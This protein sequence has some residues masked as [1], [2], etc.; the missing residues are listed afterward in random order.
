MRPFSLSKR[1]TTIKCLHIFLDIISKDLKRK[2]LFFFCLKTE[3]K[4]KVQRETK[5]GRVWGRRKRWFGWCRKWISPWSRHA[6]ITLGGCA[7]QS[8]FASSDSCIRCCIIHACWKGSLVFTLYQL[9]K[10]QQQW[11]GI[12]G[13]WRWNTE[14]NEVIVVPVNIK[15][16]S[17]V[18]CCS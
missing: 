7:E 9:E 3:S 1:F 16:G 4:K 17:R 11:V 10:N 18:Y 13:C 5:E 2:Y 12:F 15:H 6:E 14:Q 8:L